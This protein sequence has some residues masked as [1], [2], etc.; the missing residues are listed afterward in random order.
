V[1]E[2]LRGPVKAIHLA[3]RNERGRQTGAALLIGTMTTYLKAAMFFL[4]AVIAFNLG[5]YSVEF[6]GSGAA[7][8]ALVC[9]V[10]VLTIASYVLVLR[11]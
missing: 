4:V 8:I 2:S 9:D 3:R 6:S 1:R 11:S 5:R 7:W 10:I